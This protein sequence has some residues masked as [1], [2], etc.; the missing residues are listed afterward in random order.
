MHLLT[1][2]A[3]GLDEIAAPVDLAQPPGDMAALSFADSD[4]AALAAAFTHEREALPSLQIANLRDLRHPLSVD[5][6]I[7]R[8][9]AHAKVV[10]VRLIGGGEWWR[11]GVERLAAMAR[12]RGIAL[13]LLPGEDRD[14]P[15]LAQASTLP[16][17]ELAQLLRYFREGGVA[18]MRA[19][20]RR[21]AGHAG[22]P[23]DV[24]EPRPIPR[25]AGYLP[26]EGAV[27][28]DRLNE[29]SHGALAVVAVIFYRALLLAGDTA[30]ID[31]LCAALAARGLAPAALMVTSLKEADAAAFVRDALARLRPGAIV[32]TTAFAAGGHRGNHQQGHLGDSPFAGADVPIFQAVIATT[33]RTAWREG[34]RGFDA[35]DLAMNVI[36]PELDGR[37]LAG[38]I[39]FKDP[40]PPEATAELAFTAVANRP[41]PDRID[42]VAARVAALVRL[43][44]TPRASRRIVV[45]STRSSRPGRNGSRT[46]RS[47]S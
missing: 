22:T 25:F 32:T 42:A 10:V 46:S 14:D 40:L 6:W 28:I 17:E 12:E 45:P 31:A 41:E 24:P 4:L 7:E 23:L 2:T 3:M 27:D 34:P 43:A 33:S 37:V 30:A 38:A 8:V 47:A 16:P 9:G 1:T 39:A 19:L 20:L 26:G 5:L 15:Q 21:L 44:A 11:Y 36:L 18:N 29:T 35:A 13:A